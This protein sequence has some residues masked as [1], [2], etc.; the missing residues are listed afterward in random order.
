[1]FHTRHWPSHSLFVLECSKPSLGRGKA[2]RFQGGPQAPAAE[3]TLCG[4]SKS[5]TPRKGSG[6]TAGCCPVAINSSLLVPR[7]PGPQS[8]HREFTSSLAKP[9]GSVS[10]HFLEE[11]TIRAR[12]DGAAGLVP[13]PFLAHGVTSPSP[14]PSI[15]HFPPIAHK[16][17]SFCPKIL[18]CGI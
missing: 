14:L 8:H 13:V 6:G 15:F 3:G 16:P 17:V 9:F 10:D 7:V 2:K 1:M 11:D 12:P 4:H 5:A 18:D